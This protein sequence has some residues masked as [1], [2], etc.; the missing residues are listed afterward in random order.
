MPSSVRHGI[1][2]RKRHIGAAVSYF[3]T[4]L[5]ISPFALRLGYVLCLQRGGLSP[6]SNVYVTVGLSN[7]ATVLALI[8]KEYKTPRYVFQQK[9]SRKSSK[10]LFIK[11]PCPIS[12]FIDITIYM[13]TSNREV[14][15][16]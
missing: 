6:V 4:L 16:E 14:K 9:E 5:G 11:C 15:V 3:Y 7:A 12:R 10:N 2:R 1:G 8:I 13:L